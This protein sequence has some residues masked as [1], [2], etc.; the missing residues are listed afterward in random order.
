MHKKQCNNFVEK[1]SHKIKNSVQNII[2]IV[3]EYT[4]KVIYNVQTHYLKR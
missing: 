2:K 1:Q 3:G 4:K